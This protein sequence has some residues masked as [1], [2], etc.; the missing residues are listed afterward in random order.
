MLEY[1]R[2]FNILDF[3]GIHLNIQEYSYN[4]KLKVLP[5]C[6]LGILLIFLNIQVANTS[7]LLPEN[8]TKH[9]DSRNSKKIQ[10][11]H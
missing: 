9:E 6:Q 3:L 5:N 8:P 1:A 2:Y 7:K 11:A 10:G 4:S